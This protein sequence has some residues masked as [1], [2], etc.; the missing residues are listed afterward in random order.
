MLASW[1]EIEA[2]IQAGYPVRERRAGQLSFVSGSTGVEAK[3]ASIDGRERLFL[4]TYIAPETAV[5]PD[6][7]LA[8]NDRLRGGMLVTYNGK[9]FLRYTLLVGRFDAQELD[10]LIAFL[11]VAP[12]RLRRMIL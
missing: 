9:L 5:V 4:A 11:A 8:L 1:D 2:H 12:E 7:A 10:E 3:V 6:A